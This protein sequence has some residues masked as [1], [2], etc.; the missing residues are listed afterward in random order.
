MI[1][2]GIYKITNIAN[3]KIYIGSSA[4]KRGIVDRWYQHK[5]KLKHNR[6]CN[7]YLQ[8]A[9]N[10]YS[11]INFIYE[12]L[13]ECAPESC[14]EREQYYLDT[15][16]SYDPKIGYNLCKTAGNTL[17]KKHS[18]ESKLKISRNRIYGEPKYKN[19]KMPQ[20]IKDK[21][22]IAQQ[23]SIKNKEHLLKLNLSKR[24]PVIGTHIDTGEIIILDYAGADSRFNS[25]GIQMCCKGKIP[26]YKRY[27]WSYNT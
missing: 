6:H 5:S 12:I 2:H 13:E 8:K 24:I 14:L 10:K 16:K 9:Y 7:R 22:S 20:H 25:S 23:R 4:G 26:H 11:A 21:M 15:L 18:P 27:K 19:K 1:K 17:G 3:G